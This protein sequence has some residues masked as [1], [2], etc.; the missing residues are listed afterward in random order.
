MSNV[1]KNIN[2]YN[3]LRKRLEKRVIQ[4]YR[5]YKRGALK[6]ED[7]SPGLAE[8]VKELEEKEGKGDEPSLSETKLTTKFNNF[9]TA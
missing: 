1:E 9:N 3:D 8:M 7:L 6:L 2:K 5:L 4:L